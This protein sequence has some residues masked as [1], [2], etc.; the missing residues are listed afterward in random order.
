VLHV[1]FMF[2]MAFT[3]VTF[4]AFVTGDALVPARCGVAYVSLD[5]DIYAGCLK[6]TFTQSKSCLAFARALEH[7]LSQ[8]HTCLAFAARSATSAGS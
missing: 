3:Q 7:S 8:S 4:R 6:S 2:N 5:S 1:S